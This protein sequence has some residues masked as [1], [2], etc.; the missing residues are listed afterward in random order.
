MFI[1]VHLRVL[2]TIAVI[3]PTCV[4]P[5]LVDDTHIVGPASTVVLAFLQLQKELSTVGPSVQP[6]KCVAWSP[7]GLDHFISLAHGFITPNSH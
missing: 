2:C 4:F 6:M 1:L 3:H 5:S 7:Q